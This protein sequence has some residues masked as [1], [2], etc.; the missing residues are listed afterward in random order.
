MELV[1][2][3]SKYLLL[4]RSAVIQ[5]WRL[6]LWLVFTSD[7]TRTVRPCLIFNACLKSEWAPPFLLKHQQLPAGHRQPFPPVTQEGWLG[8]FAFWRSFQG[9]SH[10]VNDAVCQHHV[11]VLQN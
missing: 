3:A 2:K 9:V 6:W 1:F 8:D 7:T 4:S 5:S 11:S 10:T